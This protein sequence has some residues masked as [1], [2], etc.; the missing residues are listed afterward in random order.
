[1]TESKDSMTNKPQKARKYKPNR[2]KNKLTVDW[3]ER[4]SNACQYFQLYTLEFNAY[5]FF[6]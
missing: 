1:M 2:A 4:L 3:Q 5:T 6:Y